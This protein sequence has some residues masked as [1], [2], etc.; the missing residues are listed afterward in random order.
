MERFIADLVEDPKPYLGSDLAPAWKGAYRP[1]PGAV[2]QPLPSRLDVPKPKFGA[3]KYL[4]LSVLSPVPYC[5]GPGDAGPR[6]RGSDSAR[7]RSVHFGA[8]AVV[9]SVVRSMTSA[10]TP[11]TSKPRVGG[12]FNRRLLQLLVVSLL[13]PMAQRNAQG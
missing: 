13:L 2:D 4:S 12:Q 7:P 6:R 9:E 10:I 5:P 3:V 1:G 8:L 11:D